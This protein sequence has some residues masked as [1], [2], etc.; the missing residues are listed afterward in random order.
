MFRRIFAAAILTGT[1][2]SANAQQDSVAKRDRPLF[3]TQ[4]TVLRKRSFFPLP[5]LGYSQ[6][7]GLEIGAA[8]LYSF[9]TDNRDPHPLTR[10]STINLI[11][12]ITTENQYKIDL[13]TN[14]WTRANRWHFKSN[15][16]Y[17]DFPM[18][19]YGLGDTTHASDKSLLN[20]RRYKFQVEAERRISGN[21]YVGATALY[22]ND[23]YSSEDH[24]GIYESMSLTGK[25]GG[26]VTFLGLT[27]I[28]D[29][30]DN[31][32]Y[33]RTGTW[34]KLNVSFAPKFLSSEELTRIEAQGAQFFSFGKKSTIGF[35]GYFN[36]IQGGQIPFYQLPEMGNDLIM[37][38]YYTGR[39]RD[40]NY[41]ALQTEYRYLVDPKIRIKIWFVDLHPKFALAAFAGTGT[42]YRNK[43]FHFD[44]FKPS[45]GGGIRWF[46][47][48]SSKLTIRLDYA[49]GEKRPGEGRQSGFYLSLAEAF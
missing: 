38:G 18:Y 7:K 13:K 21:F 16:R 48:E 39:Y 4:D 28:F 47:D 25:T 12:S 42:V 9:Y 24:I 35:N 45:Y 46:Y 15:F 31:Q 32:N 10:N 2:I 27:G 37:R 19:F 22:Q 1:V 41:L 43:D 29:N 8:M 34:L 5:V 40:Q 23:S 14:I 20:N 17:H 26:H 44:G 11:P 49:V 3:G 30:R 36:T 6:E 33:T